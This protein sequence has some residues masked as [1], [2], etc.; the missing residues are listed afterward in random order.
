MAKKKLMH[1]Q[2]FNTHDGARSKCNCKRRQ[3]LFWTPTA[4]AR[5]NAN[6]AIQESGTTERYLASNCYFH[7]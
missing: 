6:P 2:A 5:S 4:L 1:L 3:S 7:F